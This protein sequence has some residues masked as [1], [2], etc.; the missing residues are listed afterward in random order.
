[1][2]ASFGMTRARWAEVAARLLAAL[3]V[4]TGTLHFA[5]PHGFESIVPRFLG[6]P[7]FWVASS[8]VVELACA[9]G[10]AYR[11]TRRRTGWTCAVLFVVVFPANITMAVHAL[12]G[13]G[14]VLISLVRLPLQ[15]PL[16]LWA[17]FIARN[18]CAGPVAD[19]VHGIRR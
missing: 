2:V 3:L 11:P 13:D 17:V 19:D 9:A 15:I 1:M 14:S 5:F 4:T 12:H 8:G 7:A 16:V 6:S 10:L 18:T